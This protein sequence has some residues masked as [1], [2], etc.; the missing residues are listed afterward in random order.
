MIA[1]FLLSR[2]SA[3]L[4]AICSAPPGKAGLFREPC[5]F[6]SSGGIN[7]PSGKKIPG[8]RPGILLGRA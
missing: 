5:C 2:F 7:P 6:Q 4:A 1:Y 8:K 3:A